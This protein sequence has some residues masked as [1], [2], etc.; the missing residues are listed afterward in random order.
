MKIGLP[1]IL[2]EKNLRTLVNGTGQLIEVQL[3]RKWLGE[4]YQAIQQYEKIE[5]T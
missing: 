3:K 2:D 5:S 4:V 1:G